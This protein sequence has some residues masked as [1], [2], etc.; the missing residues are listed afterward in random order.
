MFPWSG[1]PSDVPAVD[2]WFRESDRVWDDSHHH[3]QRAV[4]RQKTAADVRRAETPTYHPGQKVWLSTRDIRMRLLC[5]KLS[6]RFV[7]PFTILEQV[8]P[9]TYKLQLPSQYR[10]H[11]TFHVS[12]LKPHHEPVSLP[13]KPGQ[14]EQPP[15]PL[16]RGVS[17]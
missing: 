12:L 7:G 5:R 15:P 9:V 4:C 10:I 8:N 14:T 3:L 17:L 2:Y 11:P 16:R 6:P 1:E 13:S